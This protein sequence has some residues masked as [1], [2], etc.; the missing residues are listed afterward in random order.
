ME[1]QVSVI[2]VKGS[3]A[4]VRAA[5]ASACGHCAGQSAC[6]TLGSWTQRFAEMDVENAIG[7]RV[8]DEVVI[9]VP[10][11]ELLK[12]TF[13]LYGLPMLL[14]IAA[15][16]LVR[17]LAVMLQASAPDVWAAVA[18]VAGILGYYGW[19][20]L[21][22]PQLAKPAGRIIRIERERIIPIRPL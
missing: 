15:G 1:Q 8:G 16:M 9:D 6:G 12:A 22:S 17:H 13:R 19:L 20:R 11:G 4:R 21:R 14:F 3:G 5:R 2:E 7:A 18:G 10:D